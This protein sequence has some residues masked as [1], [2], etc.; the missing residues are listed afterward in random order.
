MEGDGNGYKFNFNV[1]K[2][3]GED[4]NL[5]CGWDILVCVRESIY[6]I[7]I[8]IFVFDIK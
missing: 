3:K 1:F 7:F 5:V 4:N 8:I 6:I 2:C